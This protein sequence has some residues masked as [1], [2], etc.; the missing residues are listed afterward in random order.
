[1]NQPKGLQMLEDH[2]LLGKKVLVPMMSLKSHFDAI[3]D[4]KFCAN[5]ELMVTVSEDCMMKLWDVKAFR[6]SEEDIEPLYTYR[7]HTEPLIALTTN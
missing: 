6:S 3:R 2:S 7:G 5:N 1:M 4:I